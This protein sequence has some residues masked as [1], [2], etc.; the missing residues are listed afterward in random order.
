MY[1]IIYTWNLKQKRQFHRNRDAGCQGLR[2]K[3]N[4]EIQV[5][6]YKLS[7]RRISSEDLMY[8]MMTRVNNRVSNI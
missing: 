8:S 1:D 6:G 2:G 7:D 4:G 3:E 5:K